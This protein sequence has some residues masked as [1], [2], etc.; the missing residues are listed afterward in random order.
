[1]TIALSVRI[2]STKGLNSLSVREGARRIFFLKVE[3]RLF[4]PDPDHKICIVV[5]WANDAVCGSHD[6]CS[7]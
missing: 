3:G 1:V 5:T 4:D 7:S 6:G 2:E